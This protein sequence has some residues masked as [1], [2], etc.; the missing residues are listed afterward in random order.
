MIQARQKVEQSEQKNVCV[1]ITHHRDS[2]VQKTIEVVSNGESETESET[3]TKTT[4]Y[5]TS[6]PI[7]PVTKKPPVIRE[8][9][10]ITRTKKKDK[11][12]TTEK[13]AEDTNLSEQVHQVVKD[14]SVSYIVK[15]GSSVIKEKAKQNFLVVPWFWILSGIFLTIIVSY[16][17]KRRINP[18]KNIW[19]KLI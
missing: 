9:E 14:S 8:T 7:N 15:K 5:D 16:C 4:E 2:S 13:Q 10:S 17:I 19:K 11:E 12:D 6:K 1:Q 18:I 3:V